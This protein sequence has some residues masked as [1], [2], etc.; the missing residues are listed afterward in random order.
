MVIFR[1]VFLLPR[2]FGHVVDNT[3]NLI[4]TLVCFSRACMAEIVR[5]GILSVDKG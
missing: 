3:Y 1:S 2:V 5:A 4:I